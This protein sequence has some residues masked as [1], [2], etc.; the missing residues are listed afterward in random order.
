VAANQVSARVVFKFV[1]DCASDTGSGKGSLKARAGN[2]SIRGKW[3]EA[4]LADTSALSSACADFAISGDLSQEMARPKRLVP[5]GAAVF[6]GFGDTIPVAQG[7]SF[8]VTKDASKLIFRGDSP[9]TRGVKAVVVGA[10]FNP[11]GVS[12]DKLI[13]KLLGQR[14]RVISSRP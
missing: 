10:D 4:V 5:G 9:E 14:I 13:A 1:Y 3:A 6:S 7:G 8:N 2:E 11:T 12:A